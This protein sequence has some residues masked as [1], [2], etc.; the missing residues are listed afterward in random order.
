MVTIGEAGTKLGGQGGQGPWEALGQAMGSW[1][2]V[3]KKM[4][5][6]YIPTVYDT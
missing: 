4:Y 2:I 5:Y 6:A 1:R 3:Y